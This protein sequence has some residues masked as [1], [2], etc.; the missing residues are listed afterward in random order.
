M[1]IVVQI[2]GKTRGIIE[3]DANFDQ[4]EITRFI[5]NN[6]TFKK[7]FLNM[8]IIKEIYVPKRLVNFV[9]K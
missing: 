3:V 2:N 8:K 5:T 7:Y 9:I 1:K 6:D 4:E